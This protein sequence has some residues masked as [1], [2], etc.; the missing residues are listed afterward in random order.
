MKWE[1]L[2]FISSHLARIHLQTLNGAKAPK[3][4]TC[5]TLPALIAGNG[6]ALQRRQVQRYHHHRKTSLM[7]L[8]WPNQYSKHTVAKAKM[9]NG[10]GRCAEKLSDANKE[11]KLELK[12]LFISV[13]SQSS[14]LWYR[15]LQRCF[16][17]H[18]EGGCKPL[19]P[20]V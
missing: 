16:H 8:F 13:G 19:R 1:G 6:A 20:F 15:C 12:H 11:Y 2:D 14:G 9:E 3:Q 17:Q 10:K 4:R 7:V 5:S 18:D